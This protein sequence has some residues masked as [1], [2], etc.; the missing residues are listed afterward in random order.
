[1]K[2]Q[3]GIEVS[4]NKLLKKKRKKE[5]DDIKVIYRSWVSCKST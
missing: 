3:D 5:R 1:M 2:I 4:I